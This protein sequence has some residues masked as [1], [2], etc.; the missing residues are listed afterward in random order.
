MSSGFD[1]TLSK[2]SRQSHGSRTSRQSHGSRTS[3][4][5][6]GRRTSGQS[7]GRRTSCQSH[8]RRN[9]A[10]W[11]NNIQNLRYKTYNLRS[12]YGI[13]F[14]KISKELLETFLTINEIIKLN[15]K[16]SL[17][18]G[19]PSR[20]ALVRGT[21]PRSE[22]FMPPFTISER[23]FFKQ[24]ASKKIKRRKPRRKIENVSRKK[25]VS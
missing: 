4:Q 24:M 20:A 23:F 11:S 25:K 9:S 14:Y 2:T 21:P 12:D 22:L 13:V 5:S 15:N 10:A 1:L 17:Y 3:R 18:I 8:G 19:D 16:G 7:H 6:H